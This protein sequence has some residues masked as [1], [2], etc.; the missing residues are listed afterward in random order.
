MPIGWRKRIRLG[1]LS[2]NLSKTRA[3]RG[4][5]GRPGLDRAAFES[6]IDR[7]SYR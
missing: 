6:S 4:R 1:P 7:K 5:Q 2:I 3:K